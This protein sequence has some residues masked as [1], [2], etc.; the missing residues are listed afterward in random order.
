MEMVLRFQEKER[1]YEVLRKEAE[2]NTLELRNSRLFIVMIV[3]IIFIVLGG[4]NMFYINAKKTH[5]KKK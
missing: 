4:L 2:I 3:M 1:Q 5:G